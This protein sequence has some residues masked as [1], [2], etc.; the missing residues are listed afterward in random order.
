V[1]VK[2]YSSKLHRTLITNFAEICESDCVAA[3]RIRSPFLSSSQICPVSSFSPL[4]SKNETL[5]I[6]VLKCRRN[7]QVYNVADTRGRRKDFDIIQQF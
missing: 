2:K 6:P 7:L 5:C 4:Y 1:E 3:L